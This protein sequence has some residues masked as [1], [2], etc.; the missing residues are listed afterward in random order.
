M[1]QNSLTKSLVLFL[2]LVLS[3]SYGQNSIRSC[4]KFKKGTFVYQES[5]LKDFVITR[6]RKKQIEEQKG[7][8]LIIT[9][10]IK[11]HRNCSYVLTQLSSNNRNL[12]ILNGTSINVKIIRIDGDRYEYIATQAGLSSSYTI[13]KVK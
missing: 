2:I 9:Y 4:R 3:N 6:T 11:W 1:I 12:D 8:G 7:T 13:L 10:S 5:P